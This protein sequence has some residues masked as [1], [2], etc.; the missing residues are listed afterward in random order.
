M[1]N[2][3]RYML[4]LFGVLVSAGCSQKHNEVSNEVS[5]VKDVMPI[6]KENCLSCHSKNGEGFLASGFSVESYESIMKGTKYGPVI[7][8]GESYA[9]TMLVLVDHKADPSIN[10]PR[11]APKL[12]VE[13]IKMIG[14]WISQGAKNI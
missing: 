13:N 5:F 10:M 4:L 12:S 7:Q 11:S 1:K 8:P 9:S 3:V 2:E 6:L 14:D